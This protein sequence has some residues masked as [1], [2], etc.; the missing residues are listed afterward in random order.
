MRANFTLIEIPSIARAV[1]VREMSVAEIRVL[2]LIEGVSLGS[3]L[4]FTDLSVAEHFK[5]QP[6]EAARLIAASLQINAAFFSEDRGQ[7]TE[8]GQQPAAEPPQDGCPQS[9]V[10]GH[11][12]KAVARIV[13]VGHTN[14]WD[15]PWAV[16]K[17]AVEEAE[18]QRT[19]D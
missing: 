10:I 2:M 14:A 9:S 6:D 4:L 19:E 16:F 3:L 12:E 1:T 8:D 15:Y 7:K 18:V 17:A 11:L 5:I 13:R